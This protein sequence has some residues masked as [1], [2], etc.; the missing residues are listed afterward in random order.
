MHK[1]NMDVKVYFVIAI[2]CIAIISK[3]YLHNCGS[4][5][6]SRQEVNGTNALIY[7]RG[8][9]VELFNMNIK[10]NNDI[11][12]KTEFSDRLKHL[13]KTSSEQIEQ[14]QSDAEYVNAISNSSDIIDGIRANIELNTKMEHDD[15][16]AKQNTEKN[17]NEII[18]LMEYDEVKQASN[19]LKNKRRVRLDQSSKN[20]KLFDKLLTTGVDMFNA[21]EWSGDGNQLGV[22]QIRCKMRDGVNEEEFRSF[23][24]FANYDIQID[25]NGK[26]KYFVFWILLDKG[27]SHNLLHNKLKDLCCMTPWAQET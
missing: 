17:L 25:D 6:N 9:A 11:G 2:I 19:Y 3:H 18:G 5:S 10:T 16:V 12:L 15:I 22:C 24:Q 21:V 26:D 13:L 23:K 14:G 7:F 1:G 27:S 20:N 4:I 8:G